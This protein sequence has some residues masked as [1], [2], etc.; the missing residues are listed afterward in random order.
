MDADQQA[1]SDLYPKWPA[2]ISVCSVAKL[3]LTLR[4]PGLQHARLLCPS[5]SPGVCSNSCPLSWWCYPTISSSVAPFPS[6]LPSFPASRSFPISQFF[7]SGG[8]SIGASAS[9]SV[10]PMN[11]QGCLPLRLTNLIS[12]QSKGL[13]G[14]FS[15]TTVQSHQGS[16]QMLFGFNCCHRIFH[17]EVQ[18]QCFSSSVSHWFFFQQ[19]E[20]HFHGL[21][22]L[23]D[24]ISKDIWSFVLG[25]TPVLSVCKRLIW[26][27]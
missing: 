6:H 12:L 17:F 4:P 14:V 22:E 5:P 2:H 15:S 8:Q 11:L 7:A 21:F 10:L 1:K 9:A 3:C 20:F 19:N 16:Q 25:C 26:M 27:I 23:G 24:T 13:S 18:P